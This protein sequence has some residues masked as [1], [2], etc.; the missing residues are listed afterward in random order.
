[1]RGGSQDSKTFSE[2]LNPF[3]LFT[4]PLNSR[5]AMKPCK[6]QWLRRANG[7]RESTYRRRRQ[8]VGNHAMS[9]LVIETCAVVGCEKPVLDYAETGSG[10]FGDER[11]TAGFCAGHRDAELVSVDGKWYEMDKAP[12]GWRDR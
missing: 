1:M 12:N 7:L 11:L 8:H 4:R 5:L 6:G 10:V 2:N 9:G 3:V